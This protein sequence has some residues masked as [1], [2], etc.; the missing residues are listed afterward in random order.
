[1]NNS[2]GYALCAR[3]YIREYFK[4]RC[5]EQINMK[6]MRIILLIVLMTLPLGML[7]A[8]ELTPC[9]DVAHD[10][11]KEVR[12]LGTG[13]GETAFGAL[14]EAVKDA[15][16]KLRPRFKQLY[17]ERDFEY[18]LTIDKSEGNIELDTSIGRPEIVCNE[19][20]EDSGQ[21]KAY[22]VIS[23]EVSQVDNTL[24]EENE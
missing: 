5:D 1:M 23:F 14:T 7:Y 9:Q 19:V 4:I 8:Q 16:Q 24:S 18:S 11:D 13:N 15:M 6:P 3:V 21:F 22:V 2:E 12:E 10:T 17:P 20:T